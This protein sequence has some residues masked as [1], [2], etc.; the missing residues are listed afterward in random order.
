VTPAFTLRTVSATQRRR[1][2][3]TGKLTLAVKTNSP[4]IVTVSGSVTGLTGA[5]TPIRKTAATAGTVQLTVSLSKKARARLATRGRL[6]MRLTVSHSKVALSRTITLALAHTKAKKS[7]A[8]AGS[9]TG[10]VT[11]KPAAATTRGARS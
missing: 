3:Q 10:S 4:G 1:L 7:K 2:A 8:K 11:D 5:I 6:S 9:V